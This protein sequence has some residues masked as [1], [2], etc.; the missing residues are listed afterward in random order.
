MKTMRYFLVLGVALLLTGCS[1]TFRPWNLSEVKEGMDREQVI[2]ILGEPDYVFTKDGAEHLRYSYQE[3]YSPS[4][5]SSSDL[6]YD[7]S[8]DHQMQAMRVERSM[9]VLK[10]DVLIVDGKVLN[11]KDATN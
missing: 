1:T 5:A 8:I 3:D 10:Y 4:S 7:S 2:Q 9:Q 11:Y 6:V